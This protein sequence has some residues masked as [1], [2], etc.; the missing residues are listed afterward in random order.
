MSAQDERAARLF[1][2]F[3]DRDARGNDLM[4]LQIPD[5]MTL[6]QVGPC[7]AI[8]Y[9]VKDGKKPFLHQFSHRPLLYVSSDGQTA[10]I[11][12][13]RWKFTDRGFIG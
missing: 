1:R 2:A 12:R 3:H 13:G 9:M 8:S 10:F 5:P 4:R 6:L 7:W 11:S